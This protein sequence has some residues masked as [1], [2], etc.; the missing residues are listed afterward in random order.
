MFWQEGDVELK[1]RD[2]LNADIFLLK[3]RLFRPFA[4]SNYRRLVKNQFLSTD[5]LEDLNWRK[6]QRLVQHAYQKVPF[7]RDRFRQIGLNPADILHP[8]DWQQ[9]P[10]LTREDIIQNHKKLISSDCK[11]KDLIASTTGGTTGKPVKVFHDRRYPLET[12]GWR[13]LDWWGLRPGTDAAY[14]WRL[15]RSRKSA[16]LINQIM[17]WPTKRFWLDASSMSEN[18]I[19]S[20]IST[21]NKVKPPLL[22]GYVGAIHHIAM[23]VE[24]NSIKIHSPKAVWVTASP[25]SQMQKNI[26]ERVFR[27]PLYDQYGGG[28]IFWISAQCKEQNGLHIF[29]DA[30][31]IEFVD[32]CGNPCSP[33]NSGRIVLTD[34]ENY[35]FPIIRYANGDLGRALPKQCSCGI[36]LP[37]MDSVKGRESDMFKL[38]DQSV[39]SGDYLTTLFDDFPEV[40]YAF[41]V[42]Q[43]EDYSITIRVAPNRQYDNWSQILDNV[44]NRLADKTRNQVPVNLEIVKDIPSDRGKTRF[45][46]SEIGS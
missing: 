3:Q 31:H 15:I 26:I 39:L 27:A 9:I 2:K 23:F 4:L 21:F 20:F 11:S 40:V 32:D 45:V 29:Y 19:T 12:L 35:V 25:V 13:M 36:N 33:G 1:N 10:I 6:R 5:E 24:D 43:K 44:K 46:I 28:E 14:A 34:L 8:D 7:Y 17:W 22:Q 30:R 41:Q 18:D 42:V 16:Q 38:P 37:L